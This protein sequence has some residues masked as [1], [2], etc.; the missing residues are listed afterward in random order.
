MLCLDRDLFGSVI[1]SG[2]KE[3][4]DRGKAL[5]KLKILRKILKVGAPNPDKRAPDH[6]KVERS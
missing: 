5:K 2:K 4:L 6:E 1:E 3:L